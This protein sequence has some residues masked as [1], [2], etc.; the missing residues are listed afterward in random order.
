MQQTTYK[1]RHRQAGAEEV[2]DLEKEISKRTEDEI[3]RKQMEI[4]AEK[5]NKCKSINKLCRLTD[6]MVGL[7]NSIRTIWGRREK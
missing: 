6:S 7:R 4:L 1:R 5:S 2:I 3:L